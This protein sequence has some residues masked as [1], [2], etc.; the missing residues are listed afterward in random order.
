VS[1]TGMVTSQAPAMLALLSG[2]TVQSTAAATSSALTYSV[3]RGP[4]SDLLRCQGRR[5]NLLRRLRPSP[6]RRT[7]RARLLKILSEERS[8]PGSWCSGRPESSKS[9]AGGDVEMGEMRIG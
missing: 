7:V 2:S 6:C 1:S 5:S 9:P 3:A 8:G 4:R